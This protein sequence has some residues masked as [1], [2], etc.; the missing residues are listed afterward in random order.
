MSRTQLPKSLFTA[1][2]MTTVSAFSVLPAVAQASPAFSTYDEASTTVVDTTPYNE[3]ISALSVTERGRTLM[4]Y[5]VANA[6]AL[7]FFKRYVNSLANVPVETLNR[8]E[9]LAYWLNT[10]NVLLI[11]ALSAERRVNGFKKKR[12]TP[13]E[14]GTFWTEKRITVS[15]TPLSLQDIEQ[16]IL[17]AGWDDPNIIFGLYQGISGGPAL[18][19]KAFSGVTVHEQLAA[20]GRDFTSQSNNLRVKGNAVRISSY[21]D[22]YLILA[23]DGDEA[24]MRQH[25]ADFAKPDQRNIVFADGELSRKKL[26]TSFERYRTRQ[27]NTGSGSTGAG[28]SRGYGS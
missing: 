11:Q 15:G 25:L 4:A 6:Q 7:P 2:A 16:D 18:P 3:I 10:R 20:A 13:K 12:G 21:F 5:D 24:A 26:S 14:P 27:A 8:D 19:S 23:F 9:Q 28:S 22:W 1:I 17:F